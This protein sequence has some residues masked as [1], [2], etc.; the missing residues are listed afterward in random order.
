[1]EPEVR[2]SGRQVAATEPSEVGAEVAGAHPPAADGYMYVIGDSAGSA[3]PRYECAFE[4]GGGMEQPTFEE[5]MFSEFGKERQV[6][7]VVGASGELQYRDDLPVFAG[8]E[9]KRKEE[10]LLLQAVESAPTSH[11]QHAPPPPP[12]PTTSKKSDK[13]KSDNNGIKKKKTRYVPFIVY[14]T[15]SNCR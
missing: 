13:K 8:G 2:G 15:Y 4:G 1:M 5:H 9:Q 12:P 14:N 6:Q 7:V 11:A 3:G 10:P